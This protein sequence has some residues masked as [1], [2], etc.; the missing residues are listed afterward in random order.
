MRKLLIVCF[1]YVTVRDPNIA[2]ERVGIAV[3]GLTPPHMYARPKS[4][5]RIPM[6]YVVVFF[7]FSYLRSEV[8][9]FFIY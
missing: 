4:G 1:I 9:I 3:T 5:L 2:S 8:V 7:V 6:P